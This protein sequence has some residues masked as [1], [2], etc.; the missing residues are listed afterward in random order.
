MKGG[1]YANASDVV[2]AGLRAL[3]REE[4]LDKAKLERLREAIDDGLASGFDEHF[5]FNAFMAELDREFDA[6]DR[7]TG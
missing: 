2:R 4:A 5:D 6:D 3:E 7:R 1:K